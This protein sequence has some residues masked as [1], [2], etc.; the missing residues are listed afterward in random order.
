MYASRADLGGGVVLS[1][2]HEMDYLY[3]LFG[4]PRRVFALGGHWS[5]LEID[6]EDVASVTMEF[7]SQGKPL[8]VHLQLDYLQYPPSRQCEIIGDKGKILMDLIANEVLLHANRSAS[9]ERF[10]LDA[11]ERNQLFLDE[12]K[13]FLNCVETRRQPIVTLEDGLQSLR[14]ALAAK[15]SIV[16]G[17]VIELEQVAQAAIK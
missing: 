11:F 7:T 2:I 15:E 12:L 1:Q 5:D 6:V 14:M 17:R 10:K 13:H 8:P 16:T 9:P 4:M 3:S